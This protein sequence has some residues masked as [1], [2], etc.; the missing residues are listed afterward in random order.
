MNAETVKIENGEVRKEEY[1]PAER[2]YP[3]RERRRP[4][5]YG[6]HA[7]GFEEDMTNIDYCDRLLCKVPQTYIEAVTSLNAKQWVDAMD[8]EMQSLKDNATSN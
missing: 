2:H 6:D 5:Y 8:E 1:K 3:D 4:G 7:C